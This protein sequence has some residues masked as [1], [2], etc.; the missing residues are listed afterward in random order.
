M[1][2]SAGV[3]APG[4][5]LRM[6]SS[7]Y[8]R[9]RLCKPHDCHANQFAVM[10]TQDGTRAW[11]ISYVSATSSMQSFGSPDAEMAAVLLEAIDREK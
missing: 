6:G 8:I 4:E 10:F 3:A 1:R 9:S 2:T 7:N 11:A 5:V